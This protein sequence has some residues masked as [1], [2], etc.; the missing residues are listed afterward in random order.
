M[1]GKLSFRYHPDILTTFPHVR[2]GV[3]LAHGVKNGESPQGLQQAFLAEQQAVLQQIGDT[4]LS[5][6][7]NLAAWRG[8]FRKFNVNPT[9]YR[10]ATEALLRRLTKKG[11]IPSINTLVDLGNL[12]SIR[13]Q[14]PVAVFDA[15]QLQGGIT[16][17]FADGDERFTPLFE[18]QLEYPEKGEVIFADDTDLVVAR[19]WCWRQSDESGARPDTT[20]VIICTEAQHEDSAT[21]I[22]A[23]LGDLIKLLGEYA[24]GEMISGVLD[25]KQPRISE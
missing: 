9:K 11:D 10:S 21:D 25:A 14:I 8:A 7:P 23:S 17:Q 16:V 12:V 1:T 22:N 18:T 2:A 20:D 24:G 4:P 3:I 6:L 5:D 15:S 19:R 13:Y